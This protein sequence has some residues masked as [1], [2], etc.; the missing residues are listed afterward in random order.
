MELLV[1]CEE[2]NLERE[3]TLLRPLGIGV[4]A[5]D[6]VFQGCSLSTLAFFIRFRDGVQ[7]GETNG[8]DAADCEYMEEGTAELPPEANAGRGA[9]WLKSIASAESFPIWKSLSRSLCLRLKST[10]SW[11]CSSSRN[12]GFNM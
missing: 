12:P 1:N 7:T 8:A 5:G 6:M 11:C 3:T 10:S 2:S 4:M 9:G